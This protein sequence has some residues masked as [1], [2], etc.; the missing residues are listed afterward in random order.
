MKGMRRKVPKASLTGGNAPG[1][2]ISSF[3]KMR[4]SGKYTYF[5]I[6]INIMKKDNS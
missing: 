5:G 6:K 4:G 1:L 2:L 3:F